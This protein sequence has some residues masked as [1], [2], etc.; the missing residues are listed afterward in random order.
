M[1][2]RLLSTSLTAGDAESP[3]IVGGRGAFFELADGRLLLDASNTACPLGHC[4]PE[5][6]EACVKAAGAPVLNEGWRWRERDQA[7]E[8]LLSVAFAGEDW[9][10]AVRFFVSASEAN[11]AVAALCQGI[12]G[13]APL[14]TR[15][16][17]Y[18]GG[19]G[20][21]RELTVQP[22]WHGGLSSPRA[23]EAPPR[24]AEIREI[25]CPR[26]SRVTGDPGIALDEPWREATRSRLDQAAV[27]L[28]DYSQGGTYHRPEYQDAVASLA[29]ETGTLWIADETV[30]GFGRVGGWFQF[31]HAKSRPDF[32]TLGKCMTAGGG[33][34]GAVVV[35]KEILAHMDGASWQSYSTYRAHP[36]AMAA[37]RAHLRVSKRDGVY[38]RARTL[39]PHMLERLSKLAADHPSVAR[40]DGR[41]LHWT[42][43]LHGPDWRTWRGQ[44]TEPLASKVV[45]AAAQAGALI[46]TSG[47]QTSLFIAPPLVVS[48]GELD[49]VFEALDHGLGLA[50]DLTATPS[51]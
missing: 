10:G 46:A 23:V 2:A 34:G 22:Q 47:E 25:A 41:G 15:E 11:D 13:K 36:V 32:V 49:V 14:V 5:V 27:V 44:E 17:A 8:D 9:V 26:G 30:T 4:H 31:Q 35:S 51:R 37:L 43:E 38:D 28:L 1:T 40:V 6:V 33:P 20:L 39:D 24:L 29:R 16:R 50:D 42:V 19:T 7:A 48:A 12:T 18:H 21:S 3:Q 45:A